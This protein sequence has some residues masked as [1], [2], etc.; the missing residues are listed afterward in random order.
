MTEI[1][2]NDYEARKLEEA[3][4][5]LGVTIAQLIEWLV[6]ESLDEIVEEMECE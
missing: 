6:E 2:I 3:S 5:R 1:T 4:D